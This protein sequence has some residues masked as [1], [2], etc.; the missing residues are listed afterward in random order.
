MRKE[1]KEE[2]RGS[3]EMERGERHVQEGPVEQV[4]G[5]EARKNHCARMCS[6]ESDCYH[7]IIL[8]NQ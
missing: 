8:K 2:R 5:K 4:R 7:R 6:K 1:V 3:E